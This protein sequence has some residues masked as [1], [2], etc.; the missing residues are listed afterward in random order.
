MTEDE[1]TNIVH[2]HFKNARSWT[3]TYIDPERDDARDYYRGEPFGDE[4]VGHSTVI[5]RDVMDAV[6]WIMPTMIQVF[7]G[8]SRVGEYKPVTPDDLPAADQATDYFDHIYNVDNPGFRNSYQVIKDGLVEKVG[9]WK[10]WWAE[11]TRTE[12]ASYDGL[13]R[14]QLNLLAGDD[15]VEILEQESRV[16]PTSGQEMFHVKLRRTVE[17]GRV[18]IVSI[19]P[20]D[21]LVSPQ[22]EDMEDAD[23]VGHWF[24]RSRSQL[25]AEEYDRAWVESLPVMRGRRQRTVQRDSDREPRETSRL[26]TDEAQDRVQILEA[27]V[28]VDYDG[29]GIAE[30]RKVTLGG[31][32]SSMTLGDNEEID[33]LPVTAWSP[34]IIPHEFWGCSVADLI[35]D[36]Q[37][38]KSTL[39]RQML[40]NLYLTNEPEME[41]VWDEVNQEDA[42]TREPGGIKR[43][44]QPGMYNPLAVPFVAGAAFPML[45]YLD[46]QRDGR[47]GV[48]QNATASSPDMLKSHQSADAVNKVMTTAQQRIDL[49]AR[50]FAETGLKPLMRK[51][52][53]LL[54]RHQDKE[55][56]LRLRN[57]FVPMDPR[58][59]NADMDVDVDVGKGTGDDRVM[60][61]MLLDLLGIQERALQNPALGLV[62]PKNIYNLLERLV[63][64]SG[65]RAIE[66]FFTDPDSDEGKQAAQI[67]L[68]LQQQA[69]AGQGGAEAQAFVQAEQMKQQA[70]LMEANAQHQRELIKMRLEDDRARDKMEADIR[71]EIARLEVEAAKANAQINLQAVQSAIK[72]DMDRERNFLGAV[73]SARAASTPRGDA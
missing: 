42:L 72:A 62:V 13:T 30:L 65:M 67:G 68:Q 21:L 50:V 23:F 48:S 1:L 17:E 44:R 46:A 34:I 12:T 66:P 40:D 16:E 57:Q 3:E 47:T 24:E 64:R 10:H 54:V 26:E 7:H 33:E 27:Y 53:R 43:V 45:E 73:T 52:L 22:A 19:D 20:D 39:L 60:R 11:E 9:C 41:V 61:L 51:V 29:D 56:I 15:D 18:R 4:R 8:A 5:S 70:R 69:A 32:I 63:K 14:D 2:A 49:I 38:I 36:I 37:L 31:D 59:W 35:T 71:L 28:K 25:I 55:R 6:E 58:Y